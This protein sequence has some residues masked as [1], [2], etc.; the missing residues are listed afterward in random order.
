MGHPPPGRRDRDTLTLKLC[1]AGDAGVGKTSLIRRFV[2]DTFDESYISTLGAKVS[3]RT[4]S[5][6]DPRNAGASLAVGATIWDVMGS[7]GFREMLKDAYFF[8]AQGVLLVADLTRLE[9]LRHLPGWHDVV[10]SVAGDVP[11]IALVNKTDLAKQA[12]IPIP[13]IERTLGPLGWTWMRTSAK[14]GENVE[15]AFAMLAE[16]YASSL[17]GAGKPIPPPPID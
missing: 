12:S 2:T 8:N 17:G 5:I 9:T 4:F 10:S 11:V 14:T 3:S 13:E 15:R 6:A 1:L 16:R 7:H